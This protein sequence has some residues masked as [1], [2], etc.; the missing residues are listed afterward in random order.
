MDLIEHLLIQEVL[1]V[2]Q[3]LHLFIIE[4]HEVALGFDQI[5]IG[6][7]SVFERELGHQIRPG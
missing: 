1:L 2:L 5:V 7:L 6:E 4:R 3:V